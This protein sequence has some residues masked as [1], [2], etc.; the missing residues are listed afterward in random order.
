MADAGAGGARSRVPGR[1]SPR[2]RP[3]PGL[4]PAPLAGERAG[5]GAHPQPRRARR[6]AGSDPRGS[7]APARLAALSHPAPDRK[8]PGR[9]PDRVDR[10]PGAPPGARRPGRARPLRSPAQQPEAPARAGAAPEADHVPAGVPRQ[11][12]APGCARAGAAGGGEQLRHPVPV[13]APAARG[14]TARPRRQG[15]RAGG[16]RV[17]PRCRGAAVGAR[18]ALQ[19]A[20]F[21][22]SGTPGALPSLSGRGRAAGER[23]RRDAR[24]MTPRRATARRDDPGP[25][26]VLLP[27]R[28][29]ASG[30]AVRPLPGAIALLLIAALAWVAPLGAQAPAPAPGSEVSGEAPG[31]TTIPAPVGFVNDRAGKLDEATRAKLEAFLDQLKQKTGAEFAVLIVPTTAPAVPSEYKERVFQRWGLGRKGEDNGL[32]ML[33][34]L[35][36][37][38]VRFETGYGL[39]GTLP[40]GVQSRVFR[41][42]MAPRFREGDWSGGV[43]AG[44]I[45]CA[46]RIAAEKGVTLEWDGRELRYSGRRGRTPEWPFILAFVIF[47]V[48]MIIVSNAS[49]GGGGG[50]WRRR[51]G[52]YIGPVGGGFGGFGGF[53]GGGGGGGGFGG[54]SF[55]GFGGGAS[56]GGGGGGSW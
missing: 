16:G 19:R 40:D 45:A 14:V 35:A 9:V 3:H 31:D 36:E 15:H 46:T 1:L 23:H 21:Q 24:S 56:G 30:H 47:I 37:R 42:G 6:G 8:V 27:A 54:G 5:G 25:R 2:Q 18:G 12:P 17:R 41:D 43:I 48:I 11:R 26:A 33:V 39:E 28:S 13:A 51:G 32:L 44:V 38:E 34:A 7:Q 10:H 53:G 52:W 22:G 50:R 29:L 4:R 49:R 55:G 20:A